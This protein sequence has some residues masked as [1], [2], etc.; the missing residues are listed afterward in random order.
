MAT[1]I[2]G[3]LIYLHLN[4]ELNCQYSQKAAFQQTSFCTA[5]VLLQ[6]P[7]GSEG[8]SCLL[9]IYFNQVQPKTC[10]QTYVFLLYTLKWAILCWDVHGVRHNTCES[11]QL[12]GWSNR[13]R[14]SSSQD[15]LYAHCSERTNSVCVQLPL[16]VERHRP[17]VKLPWTIYL[18]RQVHFRTLC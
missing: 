9:T 7:E 4:A 14:S 6:S 17:E 3:K 11:N 1:H 18:S 13:E 16:L 10:Q 8:N 2:L 12:R 5:H 15:H